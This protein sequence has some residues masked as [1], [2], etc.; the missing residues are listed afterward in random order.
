[1]K[2][3]E[4]YECPDLKP[5]DVMTRKMNTP[6]HLLPKGFNARTDNVSFDFKKKDTLLKRV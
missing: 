4:K 2:I 6:A 1:M 3:L 5:E